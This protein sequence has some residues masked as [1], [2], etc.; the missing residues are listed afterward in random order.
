MKRR[1]GCR[2]D[3]ME[4]LQFIAVPGIYNNNQ[5]RHIKGENH[6]T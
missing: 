3:A 5:H 1:Q 6:A 2:K 4:E